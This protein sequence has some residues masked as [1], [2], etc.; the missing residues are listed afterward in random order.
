MICSNGSIVV[1]YD[2][3]EYQL[4]VTDKVLADIPDR[5]GRVV[6][7]DFLSLARERSLS[8]S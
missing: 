3:I 4:T 5:F 1:E 7:N 6:A 8:Q 2:P